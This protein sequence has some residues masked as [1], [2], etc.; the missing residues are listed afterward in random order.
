MARRSCVLQKAGGLRNTLQG[1]SK[2]SSAEKGSRLAKAACR[3]C[4]CKVSRALEGGGRG[5]SDGRG[6]AS[7]T[8]RVAEGCSGTLEAALLEREL[9]EEV[10]SDSEPGGGPGGCAGF[11]GCCGGGSGGACAFAICCTRWAAADSPRY[12]WS[13]A[14]WAV[15]GMYPSGKTNCPHAHGKCT[16][17]LVGKALVAAARLRSSWASCTGT[18]RPSPDASCCKTCRA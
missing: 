17:V 10:E 14:S 9:L 4:P 1:C 11:G 16:S 2:T 18:G 8:V 13:N 12:T 5:D 3:R 15:A 7:G 6:F